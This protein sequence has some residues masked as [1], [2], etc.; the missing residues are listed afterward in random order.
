MTTPPKRFEMTCPNCQEVVHLDTEDG[1]V[2]D[3]GSGCNDGLWTTHGE[4]V[5]DKLGKAFHEAGEQVLLDIGM[6]SVVNMPL[7]TD[8]TPLQKMMVFS[9]VTAVLLEATL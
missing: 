4:V 6:A 3:N 8:A 7:W 9:G 5:M 1:W 2:S